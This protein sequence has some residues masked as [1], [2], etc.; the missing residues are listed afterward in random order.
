MSVDTH[1]CVQY[2]QKR[3][4]MQTRVCRFCLRFPYRNKEGQFDKIDFGPK[5]YL[6]EGP[7]YQEIPKGNILKTKKFN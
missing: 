2:N 1:C 7:Y 6:F 4:N 3:G 5:I